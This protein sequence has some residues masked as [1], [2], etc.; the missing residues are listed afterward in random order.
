VFEK[1]DFA[2]NRFE[3]IKVNKVN[4]RSIESIASRLETT[5]NDPQ[6]KGF[7]LLVARTR[8]EFEIDKA[9]EL[10]FKYGRKPAAYFNTLMHKKS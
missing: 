7:Y 1:T 5:F 4:N 6:G 2:P 8:T 9:V 3:S 10:S